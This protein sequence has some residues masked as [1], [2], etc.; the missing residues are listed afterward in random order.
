MCGHNVVI[1][2][3]CF[4]VL[5]G[6]RVKKHTNRSSEQSKNQSCR[7]P[8]A[9]LLMLC[10]RRLAS[11]G[12]LGGDAKKASRAGVWGRVPGVLWGALRCPLGE[13]WFVGGRVLVPLLCAFGFRLGE[14]SCISLDF[15]FESVS[16]KFGL[17]KTGFRKAKVCQ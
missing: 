16:R 17:E 10:L 1:L 12:R 14:C 8:V 3:F 11:S 5:R 6:G 15:A 13:F 4:A 7:L 9:S 2:C